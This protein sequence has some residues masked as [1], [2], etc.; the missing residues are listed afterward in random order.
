MKALASRHII[1]GLA[2]LTSLLAAFA[3]E[4]EA[5]EVVE[6]LAEPVMREV[7]DK[8]ERPRGSKEEGFGERLNRSDLALSDSDPFR[9]KSWYVPP[10]PPPPES[11][12][13]PTAP[14]LPF[15]YMG[16]FEDQGKATVYLVRGEESFAVAQ[17]ERF[18]EAYRLDKID[19]GVLIFSYLPLDIK[20][21][22]AIG[23]N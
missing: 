14:P 7:G 2:L 6:G 20:Q 5:Q 3:P 18:A 9:A 22:L 16:M 10:P 12:P 11:L 13:K 1:L 23:M 4:M 8:V 21:T 19:Q 17:G 15:S